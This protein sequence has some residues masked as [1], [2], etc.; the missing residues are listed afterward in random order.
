MNSS[1][2]TSSFREQMLTPK[3]KLILSFS[4]NN[5]QLFPSKTVKKLNFSNARESI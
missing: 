1:F 4:K 2:I 5:Q 3:V